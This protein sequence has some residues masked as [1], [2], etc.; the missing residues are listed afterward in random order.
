MRFHFC[1]K[2][3]IHL[4]R[5]YEIMK[6]AGFVLYEI[7]CG[8]RIFIILISLSFYDVLGC[9]FRFIRK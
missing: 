9:F 6:I 8:P 3:Y 4:L 2:N 1:Y 7:C 5:L